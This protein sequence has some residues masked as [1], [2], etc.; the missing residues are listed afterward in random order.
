MG[1]GMPVAASAVG[2]FSPL[3][4]RPSL[5]P[6]RRAAE[7][8][9]HGPARRGGAVASTWALTARA[10]KR[11]SR[12]TPPRRGPRRSGRRHAGHTP[13][14][15]RVQRAGPA[16]GHPP[17]AGTRRARSRSW[18]CGRRR[19]HCIERLQISRRASRGSRSTTSPLGPRPDRG[20]GDTVG[21]HR[22][23]A[24]RFALR[25][26]GGTAVGGRLGR[27]GCHRGQ[28][29]RARRRFG[30]PSGSPRRLRSDRRGLGIR[31]GYRVPA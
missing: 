11:I 7:R 22:R 18:A 10:H 9:T 19:A 30:G 12:G 2:E 31:G 15:P 13:S 16:C 28:R 14:A 20:A 4:F 17:R 24:R 21:G 3:S 29:P 25:A 5:P 27:T 23:L 6:G 1:S 8:P 26:R